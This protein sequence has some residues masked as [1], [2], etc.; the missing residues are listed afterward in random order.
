MVEEKKKEDQ[1]IKFKKFHDDLDIYNKNSSMA[2]ISAIADLYKGVLKSDIRNLDSVKKVDLKK[3]LMDSYLTHHG[4]Y[5]KKEFGFDHSTL[6]KLPDHLKINTINNLFHVNLDKESNAMIQQGS[7]YDFKNHLS[8]HNQVKIDHQRESL[9]TEFSELEETV[10]KTLIDKHLLPGMEKGYEF[11]YGL[12]KA[13][14]EA[15][16]QSIA[17]A[18]QGA[19]VEQIVKSL[20]YK[21]K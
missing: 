1:T 9:G 2:H 6:N 16:G 18:Y 8:K 14:P 10:Q 15:I 20:T 3:N 11:N 19:P 4:G 13:Q 5:L 21:K 17:Q 12:L 7:D